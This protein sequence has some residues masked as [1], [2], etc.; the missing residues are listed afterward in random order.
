M[1]KTIFNLTI[2]VCISGV[3]MTACQSSTSKVEDAKDHVQIATENVI[4]ANQALNQAL[5]DSIQQFRT[6]SEAKIR[7]NE[8][9]IAEFKAKIAKEKVETKMK[10]EKKLAELEQKNKDLISRL[11]NYKD[12]QQDKWAKFKTEYNHDMD[13]LGKAFK[14]LTIKNV[15]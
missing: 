4:E 12:V 11:D 9:K 8:K 6:A 2:I 5:K 14:D 7:I 13:E 3:I 15:K 1:K 10:N